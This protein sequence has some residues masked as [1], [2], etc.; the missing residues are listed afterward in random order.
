MNLLVAHENM[1]EKTAYNIVKTV[2][3]H[4]DELIAC[5]R[6]RRTSSSRTRR[7][8]RPADSMASGRAQYFKE[9]G[10]KLELSAG[11]TR[12]ENPARPGGAFS[13]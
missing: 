9:K 12:R 2:F 8:R 7:P 6:K 11:A 10:V 13:L 4:R 3:E 1:N 5:T